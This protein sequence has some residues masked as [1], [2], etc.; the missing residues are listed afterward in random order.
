MAVTNI[1]DL[2]VPDIWIRGIDEQARNLPS[3]MTSGAVV[4]SGVLDGIASGGGVSANL[5]FFKDITDLAEVIQVENVAAALEKITSGRNVAPILNRQIAF[6]ASALSAGVSGDDPIGGITRQMAQHR[7][8]RTMVTLLNVLSGIF[9]AA[10]ASGAAAPLQAVRQDNF[11]ED[12]ATTIPADQSKYLIDNAKFHQAAALMGELQESLVN[13]AIWMHPKVRASL[14]TQDSNSF[15]RDSRGD[16][17]LE[18]YKGFPIYVSN[19]LQRAGTTSGFVYY[20]YLLAAGV[21]GWGEK[22]QV[23]DQID[24]ASLQF[25]RRPDINEEQIYDRR[26]YLA[27]INGMRFIGVPAGQSA[28]NAE[29]ATTASWSLQY[30]SADR[31]GAVLMRTNG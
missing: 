25:Y 22:P 28:T 1:A 27:H 26:R 12:P 6:A 15:E 14:I 13:G 5:P 29:L 30:Q 18:R 16:F 17:I 24:V 19:L 11:V 2:W 7:Q 21:V 9:G 31:V 8:K 20:T 23:G 10:G 4:R 3:L